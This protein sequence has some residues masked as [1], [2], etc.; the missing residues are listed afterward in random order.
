MKLFIG[1]GICGRECWYDSVKVIQKG[2]NTIL[3]VPVFV[4]GKSK[5]DFFDFIIPRVKAEDLKGDLFL[6][7]VKMKKNKSSYHFKKTKYHDE[8]V[9]YALIRSIEVVP[10][11]VYIQRSM[12]DKVKVIKHIRFVDD[13]VDLGDFLCNVYFIRIKLDREEALPFYLT[14]TDPFCLEKHYIFYR[15]AEYSVNNGKTYI[16]LN[17]KNR[18]EYI[19]LSELVEN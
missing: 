19:S 1:K 12:K 14:S 9:I 13:E 4:K 6:E 11:D 17:D 15:L 5:H 3:K 8:R 16:I 2:K 7:N 10:D 18:N